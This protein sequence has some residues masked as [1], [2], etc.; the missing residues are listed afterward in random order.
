MTERLSHSVADT[1]QIAAEIA[2]TLRGGECIAL[3]GD[4]GAG[5]TQFVRGLVKALGGDRAA[6]SSPTFVLLHVYKT[7]T[8]TVYHLDAYRVH[9]GEDFEQIGF[10]ELLEQG[11]VVVVE[12]AS[13]VQRLIPR[14]HLEVRITTTGENDR[15]IAIG[16]SA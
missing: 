14:G 1:E 15:T 3:H 10:D 2:Q 9:G 13:R 12:W 7:S 11:G 8:L 16:R 5:K 4:L 6:V